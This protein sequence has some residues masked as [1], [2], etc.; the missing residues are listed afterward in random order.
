[1]DYPSYSQIIEFLKSKEDEIF[2]DH[3]ENFCFLESSGSGHSNKNIPIRLFFHAGKKLDIM[4][5]YNLYP[6][7]KYKIKYEYKKLKF[8]NG[9]CSPRAY[10]FSENKNNKFG[11]DI[12]ITEYLDGLLFKTKFLS[13]SE[14]N[15]LAKTLA[16]IHG[17]SFDKFSL[18]L[19]FPPLKF[20]GSREIALRKMNNL[21]KFFLKSNMRYKNNVLA[22]FNKERKGLLK[23]IFKFKNKNNHFIHG[24]LR[25]HF[26]KKDG[27]FYLL[28]WELSRVGDLTEDLSHF[29]YF[30]KL[31]KDTK[32]Y[33]LNS[34]FKVIKQDGSG[35]SERIKIFLILEEFLGLT[36]CWEQMLLRQ[37]KN[38]KY[39]YRN[40]F[41]VRYKNLINS[42]PLFSS[43]NYI[44]LAGHLQF[45]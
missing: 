16:I 34:Y 33:F 9:Q 35:I 44:L 15:I 17:L 6:D 7:N 38:E 11:R 41:E 14:L 18:K 21:E 1:M 26:I 13:L 37:D 32:R 23:D 43:K 12:L 36:W 30:S 19:E 8:L 4:L 27:K 42:T 3:I 22:L 20:G 45:L 29:L 28:D 39:Y 40:L 5:R 2:K 10:Y 25:N 31:S 24:D